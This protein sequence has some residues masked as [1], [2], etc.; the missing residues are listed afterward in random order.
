MIFISMELRFLDSRTL[1]ERNS[2]MK[3]AVLLGY[4]LF[5]PSKVKY[6]GYIDNFASFVNKNRINTVVLSGGR[7][8]P[9]QPSRSEAM[10]IAEYLKPL[11]K[12]KT[13]ILLEND[14]L[15]SSQNIEFTERFLDLNNSSVTVF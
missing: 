10:S 11:I 14:S 15:T 2:M 1:I 6:K 13:K 3:Y 5:E 9:K 8:D 7:T 4:G 12:T